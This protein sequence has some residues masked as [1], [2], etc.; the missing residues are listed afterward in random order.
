MYYAGIIVQFY[1]GTFPDTLYPLT[2]Y[3]QSL[4]IFLS[5]FKGKFHS[6]NYVR[7]TAFMSIVLFYVCVR[8]Y[9]YIYIK[10]VLPKSF[11]LK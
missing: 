2:T 9:V 10:S 3:I 4:Y 7:K 5:E 11:S 1:M 6:I 8:M